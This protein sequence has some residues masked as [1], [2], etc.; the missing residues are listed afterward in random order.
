MDMLGQW[1]HNVEFADPNRL[2]NVLNALMQIRAQLEIARSGN[3]EGMISDD[4]LADLERTAT[5]AEQIAQALQRGADAFTNMTLPQALGEGAGNQLFGGIGDMV[6][7]AVR[8]RNNLDADQLQ[9]A[10]DAYNLAAGRIT[11]LSITMRD[12]IIPVLARLLETQGADVATQRTRQVEDMLRRIQLSGIDENGLVAQAM[13]GAS[14]GVIGGVDVQGR[15]V[16]PFQN[17]FAQIRDELG[18]V[19]T[20]T[21]QGSNLLGRMHEGV[22]KTV[23][24]VDTL[25]SALDEIEAHEWRVKVNMEVNAPAWIQPLLATNGVAR[26]VRD[27]GGAVPGMDR[28]GGRFSAE[29][30]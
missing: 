30:R 28:R 29:P 25:E 4:E 8:E 12:T 24:A 18:I 14:T 6:L 22:D 3:E 19:E 27:N 2:Q 23:E 26:I 11:E 1:S 9:E 13:L 5:T 7:D 10:A 16:E 17:A 20:D 21:D 15:I